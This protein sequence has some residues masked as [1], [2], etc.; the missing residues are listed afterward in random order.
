[1]PENKEKFFKRV[2]PFF[3]LSTIRNIEL[4]YYLAK[5]CHRSQFR[6]EFD[7]EGNPLRYFEHL[8]RVAL[9][10]IDEAKCM[11]SEMII[12]AILHDSIEDTRDLTPE[13]IEHVFGPDICVLVK[14]LSKLPEEGYI[15]RLY[16]CNDWRPIML[17]ACDRLDNLRSL[18]VDGNYESKEKHINFI[19]KQV[20]E[21]QTKYL[22]LFDKMLKMVP[23]EYLYAASH[24]RDEIRKNTSLAEQFI[25]N[26]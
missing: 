12:A 9:I 19:T 1:M 21:T 26:Q 17:K 10:L 5:H 23:K 6:K 25:F 16:M 14:T 24:L 22:P 7:K 18:L 4:A 2:N 20:K 8:R 13:L 3:A 15:D 11:R